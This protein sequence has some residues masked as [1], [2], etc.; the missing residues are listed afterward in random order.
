[1]IIY[2]HIGIEI[3]LKMMIDSKSYDK[4]GIMII[5]IN[6]LKLNSYLKLI[7]L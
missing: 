4:N 6:H 1:M 5:Q 7:C 3:Y 2:L